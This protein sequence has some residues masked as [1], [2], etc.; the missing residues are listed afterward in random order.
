MRKL[1]VAVLLALCLNGCA[2]AEALAPAGEARG[3]HAFDAAAA[4]QLTQARRAQLDVEFF[5]EFW[6]K[7]ESGPSSLPSARAA[8]IRAMAAEGFEVAY[9]ADRLYNF[10]RN[11]I[12]SF[13]SDY[14][15]HWRRLK[16]LAKDGDPSAQC[17]FS[18]TAVEYR[19]FNLEPPTLDDMA[20]LAPQYRKAAASHGH[21]YCSWLSIAGSGETDET[22]ITQIAMRCAK[23][24][25]TVCQRSLASRYRNG[26][27]VK[28][29]SA[30]GF[31]WLTKAR[32]R[33]SAP[34][35]ENAY[36]NYVGLLRDELGSEKTAKLL[37]DVTADTDCDEYPKN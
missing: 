9:L 35:V 4:G 24:G 7:S 12:P 28:K 20:V 2:E 15:T 6:A 27:G 10:E 22:R 31:C 18:H 23:A 34:S 30:R 3:E 5:N 33:N 25:V 26:R 21:P 14:R 36:R 19:A 16:A 32:S 37:N 1:A 29:D 8:R 17:L 11:G 13:A